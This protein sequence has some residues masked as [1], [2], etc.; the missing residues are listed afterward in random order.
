MKKRMGLVCLLAC[1]LLLLSGCMR[2]GVGVMEKSYDADGKAT[3]ELLLVFRRG[4]ILSTD[5]DAPARD[6]K[7]SDVKLEAGATFTITKQ[8]DGTTI[9][10]S[11]P[12]IDTDPSVS[13]IIWE[14]DAADATVSEAMVGI[15]VPFENLEP[16]N[17]KITD[18]TAAVLY[19]GRTGNEERNTVLLRS[20]D[21]VIT[22]APP[23][24]PPKPTESETAT[25]TA[26]ATPTPTPTPTATATATVTVTA[27]PTPTPTATATASPA[28]TAVPTA[29]PTV[30]PVPDLP[31]TGD[32]AEVGMW[33]LLLLLCGAGILLVRRRVHN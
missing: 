31:K 20:A 24:D 21:F 23:T 13:K 32:N 28:V 1:L 29:T 33:T 30:T 16:G 25:D 9:T 3:G 26:T 12:K 5:S 18:G 14:S 2:G 19:P 7:I 17:Y 27:T 10:V 11:N 4:N 8:A 15:R 22:T 6:I